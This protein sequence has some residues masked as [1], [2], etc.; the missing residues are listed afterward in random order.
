MFDKSGMF[1][2]KIGE[3]GEADGQFSSPWGLCVKKYDDHQNLLVCD[4][5]NG[6]IQQFTMEGR[7]IGK[8]FIKQRD[9]KAIATTPD[10]R[11]LVCDYEDKNIYILK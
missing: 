9:P 5:D 11:I 10:D 7:F 3:E 1:L 6:R 4:S 2:Y 8:T